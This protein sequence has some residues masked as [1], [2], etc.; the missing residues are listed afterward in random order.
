M[1]PIRPV[2]NS[3]WEVSFVLLY[4]IAKSSIFIHAEDSFESAAKTGL[5]L[6]QSIE[7][8]IRV[9]QSD[10]VDRN[11]FREHE[12]KPPH[13]VHHKPFSAV[14]FRV[15]AFEVILAWWKIFSPSE[16]RLT[17]I[18]QVG[19]SN[20]WTSGAHDAKISGFRCGFRLAMITQ[21]LFRWADFDATLEFS[22]SYQRVIARK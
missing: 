17:A 2:F 6:K 9:Q 13:I 8:L 12:I 22:I 3:L 15:S 4:L 20:R 11:S 18:F 10:F 5:L 1:W 7:P 16:I 21:F 19:V 14:E